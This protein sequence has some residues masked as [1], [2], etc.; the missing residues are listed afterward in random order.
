L[1]CACAALLLGAFALQAHVGSPDVFFEGKAGPYPVSIAIRPP[2][3]VPGTAE[4]EVRTPVDSITSIR[5]VP[6][7][8]V[9]IGSKYPPTSDLAK[10][11]TVDPHLYTS[12]V[13]FMAFGSYQVRVEVNGTQ[14]SGIISVPIPSVARQI[15]QMDTSLGWV[16]AFLMLLIVA[17]AVSIAGAAARESTLLE[18][19]SP[20][21][22]RQRYARM[23]MVSTTLA[24]IAILA[25][26]NWWWGAEANNYRAH[27][28]RPPALRADLEKGLLHLRL[29]ETKWA[30]RAKLNDFLPDHDHLMHLFIVRMPQMERMWHLHPEFAGSGEFTQALPPMPAGSYKLFADVVHASGFPET[31]IAD[32]TLPVAV[33][34]KPVTGD[35]AEGSAPPLSAFAPER[36][37]FPLRNGHRMVRLNA[38]GPLFAKHM[39][40]LAFEVQDNAGHPVADLEPYMGMAGHAEF[41]LADASVFAHVH[42]SGTVPMASLA[43]TAESKS[44]ASGQQFMHHMQGASLPAQ[45][46]FPFGFPKAGR[47]RMFIQIQRAGL[48]ETASFDF[49]VQDR[50][51]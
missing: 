12:S 50:A 1:R 5:V 47:Y 11:S 15:K 19:E 36:T 33:E 45:L 27:I 49:N 3:V 21:A 25:L 42:P 16:L 24:I 9:G 44:A 29:S 39:Q 13:W 4:V 31:P 48:P 35:D 40:H 32:F 22:T 37:I 8:L 14:E 28:Y 46:A 41:L 6:L 38:S 17:G 43:L 7:P 26:G 34:G 2:D 10:R 23:V 20:D 51:R 18:G 30:L